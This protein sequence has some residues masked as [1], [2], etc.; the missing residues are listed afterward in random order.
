MRPKES[1]HCFIC[2]KCVDR[3]DHHCH[4]VNNC[5]GAGNHS[6]FYA[7]LLFIWSYIMFTCFIG[8]YNFNIQIDQKQLDKLALRG[9]YVFNFSPKTAKILFDVA[10]VLI[11]LI[12]AV[13][14]LPLSV[15]LMVQ[16]K[17]F[18]ANKTTQARFKNNQVAQLGIPIQEL[19][20]KEY[21]ESIMRNYHDNLSLFLNRRAAKDFRDHLK[22]LT[23]E[24]SQTEKD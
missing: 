6:F 2:D 11:L 24:S 10:I 17:N 23:G 16:T 1:R 18:L 15:L 20:G 22:K 21:T 8:V 7:Y 3:F 9:E 12:S 4:W 14:V 19:K 13:F 5:V